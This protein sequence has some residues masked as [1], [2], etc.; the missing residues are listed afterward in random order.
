LSWSNDPN[1]I[2]TISADQTDAP[3]YNLSGQRLQVGKGNYKGIV[4]KNGKKIL[5]K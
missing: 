4:I 2:R 5:M 3:V 1:G